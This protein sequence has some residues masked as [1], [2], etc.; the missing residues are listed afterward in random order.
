MKKSIKIGV[1]KKSGIQPEEGHFGQLRTRVDFWP[2]FPWK[3]SDIKHWK[4]H[5]KKKC[6]T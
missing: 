3:I 4:C 6:G 1:T 2:K 5:E